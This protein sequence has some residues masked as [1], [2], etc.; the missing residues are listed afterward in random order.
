ML[1]P[2]AWSFASF[3]FVKC[4]SPNLSLFMINLQILIK[5]NVYNFNIARFIAC[6]DKHSLGWKL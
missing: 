2:S 1:A 4:I 5:Y 6:L 3:W